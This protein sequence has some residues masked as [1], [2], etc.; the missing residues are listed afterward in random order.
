M[1]VKYRLLAALW[2]V[3]LMTACAQPPA[4]PIPAQFLYAPKQSLPQDQLATLS[5]SQRESKGWGLDKQT[6]YLLSIDGKMVEGERK[7]WN[8]VFELSAGQH[9]ARV[10]FEFGNYRMQGTLQFEARAQHQ[11]RLNFAGNFGNW[12]SNNSQL[13]L[14]IEDMA[15]GEKVSTPINGLNNVSPVPR[16]SYLPVIINK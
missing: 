6:A 8:Q 5:G 4:N 9:Q 12:L 1:T 15:T 16:P 7:S 3:L 13:E 14:W 2:P 10:Q 11:Y